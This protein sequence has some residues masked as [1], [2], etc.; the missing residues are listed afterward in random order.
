MLRALLILPFLLLAKFAF[1]QAQ[2]SVRLQIV[3]GANVVFNVNSY[4]KVKNGITYDDYTTVRVYFSGADETTNEW[5]LL[6]KANN[7][8]MNPDYGTKTLPLDVLKLRSSYSESEGC[9]FALSNTETQLAYGN[10]PK[11]SAVKDIKISYILGEDGTLFG[12]SSDYF[13]TDLEF[14]VR[15]K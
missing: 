2:P 10:H 13:S 1:P 8:N 15:F 6:V 3:G 14:T 7:A 4:S 11:T 5:E 9:E 12:Y